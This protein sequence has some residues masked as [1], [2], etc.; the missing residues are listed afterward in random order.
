MVHYRVESFLRVCDRRNGVPNMYISV[1]DLEIK[2]WQRTRPLHSRKTNRL[3]REVHGNAGKVLPSHI[4]VHLNLNN[5]HWVL[6]KTWPIVIRS[7]WQ[8]PWFYHRPDCLW[9]RHGGPNIWNV[10]CLRPW[11][12]KE[13]LL[14]TLASA[15]RPHGRF[16]SPLVYHQRPRSYLW[17]LGPHE[18]RL[19]YYWLHLL[20]DFVCRWHL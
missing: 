12:Q 6:F 14:D 7:R 1:H 2:S 16:D 5:V 9:C 3:H 10:P 13:N 8:L 19:L 17:L 11:A 4:R 18:C 15:F 20:V